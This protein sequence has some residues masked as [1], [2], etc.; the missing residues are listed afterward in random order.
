[1][2]PCNGTPHAPLSHLTVELARE[3]RRRILRQGQLYGHAD[4]GRNGL[5]RGGRSRG[6]RAAAGRSL[7]RCRV[8][9]RVL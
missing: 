3:Y 8:P 6:G 4:R 1:M 7:L 2:A 9:V 5:E